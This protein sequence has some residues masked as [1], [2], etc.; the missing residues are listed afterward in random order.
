MF[1]RITVKIVHK[2]A[3]YQALI[4]LHS[5]V[6]LENH[7]STQ[8]NGTALDVWDCDVTRAHTYYNQEGVLI[9]CMLVQSRADKY[10]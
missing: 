6:L 2:T 3:Y 9:T 8:C 1:N 5:S 10:H 7:F 4:V